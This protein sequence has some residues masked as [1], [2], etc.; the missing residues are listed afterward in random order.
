MF[1][2]VFSHRG[3]TSL[4]MKITIGLFGFGFV[5]R[6]VYMVVI[7]SFFKH[8]A[9][10][11][12]QSGFVRVTIPTNLKWRPGM[13]VFVRFLHV[14]PFESHPFTIS[15]LPGAGE[16]EE[17]QRNELVFLVKMESGF[18]RS[19]GDC[20]AREAPTRQFPVILDGPYGES[21]AN[22]LRS[23]DSV[24]LLAG[25]M[26][27]TFI[28]PILSDLAGSMKQNTG[29]CKTVDV[30]LSAKHRGEYSCSVE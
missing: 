20:A 8:R 28:A 13:H 10:L 21:G 18:T 17:S 23:Y 6:F 1:E 4:Y 2:T 16:K 7:S 27:V 14:R 3:T 12:L 19:L 5:S 25:G 15:S 9:Q 26:G 30:V 29:I 11:S 24:L 22:T